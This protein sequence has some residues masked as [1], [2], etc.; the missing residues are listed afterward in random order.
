MSGQVSAGSSPQPTELL[1]KCYWLVCGSHRDN[2][3][4]TKNL[5]KKK[6]L[7]RFESR[8]GPHCAD[9]SPRPPDHTRPK[10]HEDDFYPQV[11]TLHRPQY[12]CCIS[13]AAVGWVFFWISLRS[14]PDKIQRTSSA[15]WSMTRE[16]RSFSPATSALKLQHLTLAL[17]LSHGWPKVLRDRL[18]PFSPGVYW[19]FAV[20]NWFKVSAAKNKNHNTCRKINEVINYTHWNTI[21]R[22]LHRIPSQNASHQRDRV[23]LTTQDKNEATVINIWSVNKIKGIC[24]WICHPMMYL[25]SPP[26]LVAVCGPT[27]VV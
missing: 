24:I 26:V 3:E 21:V 20:L 6:S 19:D 8:T 14:A 23:R 17:S 10:H 4:S 12:A 25:Q 7:I 5:V 2:I 11:C 22:S 13:T 9:C 27:V 16:S 18:C 15:D 1:S